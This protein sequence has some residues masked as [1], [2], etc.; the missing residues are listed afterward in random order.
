[1]TIK[2]EELRAFVDGEIDT[3]RSAEIERLIARDPALGEQ[4]AAMEASR[5]PYRAAYVNDADT[6]PEGLRNTVE[7]W[8]AVSDAAQQQPK[9]V[10]KNGR[11]WM[12]AAALLGALGLGAIAGRTMTLG[13]THTITEQ[14]LPQ[15]VERVAEY[16]SLYVRATVDPLGESSGSAKPDNATS[17]DQLLASVSE[18]TGLKVARPDLSAEGYRFV[19]AQELGFEGQPLIQLVYLG[20]GDVPLAFCY[21]PGDDTVFISGQHA[22]LSVSSWSHDEQRFVIVADESPETMKRLQQQASSFWL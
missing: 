4:A 17:A 13:S 9:A 16:Q 12:Y 21:M 7:S 19:R 20:E 11:K 5:L 2:L 22:G 8:V 10:N 18:R 6:L 3:T 14:A 15:W 1:M